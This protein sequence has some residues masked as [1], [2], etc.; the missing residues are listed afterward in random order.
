MTADTSSRAAYVV[1]ITRRGPPSAPFGW[2]ICRL[3]DKFELKRSVM[4]FGTQAEA[5]ANSVQGAATLALDFP[6][7]TACEPAS[8]ETSP[9]A[10]GS[11]SSG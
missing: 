4:T 2:Q 1:R 11:G 3:S 8:I 9:T 10:V 6:L 7:G 5:I